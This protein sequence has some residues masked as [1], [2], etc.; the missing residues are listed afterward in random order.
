MVSN[1]PILLFL[2]LVN[3]SSVD[4]SKHRSEISVFASIGNEKLLGELQGVTSLLFFI[5]DDDD[6]DVIDVSVD[7]VGG[8]IMDASNFVSDSDLLTQ[9]LLV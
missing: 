1:E 6:V 8:V 4:G 2:S 3:V 7:V 9:M 5:D